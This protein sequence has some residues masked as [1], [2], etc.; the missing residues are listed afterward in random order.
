MKL[1]K[2][3]ALILAVIMCFSVLTVIP[4]TVSA[5]GESLWENYKTD[6]SRLSVT[7]GVVV[8]EGY[9][10][11]KITGN[12]KNFQ[13]TKDKYDLT[14]TTFV[15]RDL[16]IG[17]T[18]G[19]YRGIV[20]FSNEKSANTKSKST[21]GRLSLL[22]RDTGSGIKF[23]I[24]N[25]SGS[26]TGLGTI[27]YAD[28]YEIGFVKIWSSSNKYIYRIRL[29]NKI[30]ETTEV[31]NFCGSSTGSYIGIS[32]N[33]EFTASYKFF[34]NNDTRSR[35][36]STKGNI[37]KAS[38]GSV[39]NSVLATSL[40][41]DSNHIVASLSSY[42]MLEDIFVIKDLK[43]AS[44]DTNWGLM[45]FSTNRDSS[46]NVTEGTS[47]SSDTKIKIF[48]KPYLEDTDG[49]GVKEMT[50]LR[51]SLS[52]NIAKDVLVPVA[53]EYKF[54]FR[55]VDGKYRLFINDVQLGKD[56][57]NTDYV[58]TFIS[59]VNT[60]CDNGNAQKC[61][62]SLKADGTAFIAGDFTVIK[63]PKF[64]DDSMWKTLYPLYKDGI[65]A[66]VPESDT[67][68]SEGYERIA[69]SNSD[70]STLVTKEKYVLT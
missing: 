22:V 12:E 9:E 51:V 6:G 46:I 57:S 11:I 68:A 61:Y 8:P 47:I 60:F 23:S 20:V 70:K 69:V 38:D 48:V 56:T 13:V 7:D 4:T 29:N 52:T 27:P 35:W 30:Y 32:S 53:D 59:A 17:S 42:N 34:N 67:A 31:T 45:V 1:K 18:N 14:E 33:I 43:M 62:I 10:R 58:K 54:S 5:A 15:L 40:K 37:V 63:N 50:N 39:E 55:Y 21:E 49:D 28:E 36:V 16:Y 26:E 3:F 65:R 25:D 44:T 24:Y 2:L 64:I 19:A 41:A 66:E